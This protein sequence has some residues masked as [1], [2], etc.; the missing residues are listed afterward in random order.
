MRVGHL[1]RSYGA[2]SEVFVQK[3]VHAVRDISGPVLCRH[4]VNRNHARGPQVIA[5]EDGAE[6]GF[7][8]RFADV[9]YRN[10]RWCSPPER[11]WF[12]EQLAESR[13]DLV[14]GQFGTDTRY[15]LH[16]IQ[17]ADLPYVVHFHGYDASSFPDK[18]GGLGKLYLKPVWQHA[19]RVL[20]V[21]EFM[22]KR[23]TSLGCPERK[24]AIVHM[25]ID[26]DV[27]EFRG[28]HLADGPITILQIG[29]FVQKKGHQFFLDAITRLTQRS[30]QLPSFKVIMGG[31]GPLRNEMK[32]SA[33]SLGLS[34]VVEFPGWLDHNQVQRLLTQAHL[35]VQPSVTAASGDTEGIPTTLMEAMAAGLPIISTR[36]TGIPELV[37]E[38]ASGLLVDEHDVQGLADALEQLITNPQHWPAMGSAGR[39]KVQ[40]EFSLQY[41]RQRLGEI[42]A[43]VLD[44]AGRSS[45]Q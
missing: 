18:F 25:A 29:R 28:R 37:E 44:E 27:I 41:Q 19:G 5:Y 13:C 30:P 15:F 22:A 39:A 4:W 1:I 21:S 31:D 32:A 12:T 16:A 7:Q 34:G 36:H 40:A 43:A 3:L 24:L 26:C 11:A 35:F 17:K 45:D 10:L 6:A 33:E 8:R 9:A 38:G 23:L 2:P 14:H 42:Y 20:T